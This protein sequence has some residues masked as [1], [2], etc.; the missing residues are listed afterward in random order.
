M[1][2][3]LALAAGCSLVALV[4]SVALVWLHSDKVPETASA[5]VVSIIERDFRITAPASV[6]AG[7]AVLR[8]K[9]EGPDDHELIV[10]KEDVPLPRRADAVTI[11]EDA[12]ESRTI[13]TLEPGEPGSVRDLHVHLAPGRYALFCNMGGHFMGGMQTIVNVT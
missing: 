11:D 1:R 10:V 4:G 2:R 5:T 12:V 8:V 7:D 3:W 13:G 6:R 9:N